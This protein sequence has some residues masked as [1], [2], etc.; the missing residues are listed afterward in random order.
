[1]MMMMIKLLLLYLH[2]ASDMV[3]FALVDDADQFCIIILAPGSSFRLRSLV[4]VV[5][6]A[7]GGVL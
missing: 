4:V 2:H 3:H 1:M 7:V 5:L 6:V